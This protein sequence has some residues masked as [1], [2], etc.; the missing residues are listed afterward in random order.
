M[1]SSVRS[2]PYWITKIITKFEELFNV[3]LGTGKTY[4]ADSG[5]KEDSKSICSRPYSVP[6][7]HK[8]MFRKKVEHLVLRGTLERASD[9]EWVSPYFAQPKPK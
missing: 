2:T 7:V 5:L 6:K 4:P 8:K 3:T 1:I 9:S